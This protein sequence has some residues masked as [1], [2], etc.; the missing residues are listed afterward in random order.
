MRPLLLTLIATVLLV[1]QQPPPTAAQQRP[2]FRGGTQFIR[3]DAYPTSRD[4]RII[5]GLTADD[6]EILEDGKPQKVDSFDFIKFATFTPEVERRDPSSQREGFDM[7]ADPRYRVFVIFVDMFFSNTTAAAPIDTGMPVGANTNPAIS[8]DVH[9]IQRPLVQFLDRIL[10]P[11]DLYGFLTSRNSVKDLVLAQKSTVTEAQIADLFRASFIERDEADQ[12]DM[13]PKLPADLLELKRRFRADASYTALEGLIQQ[14]GSLRQE[15]KNVI[16][17]SNL[18]I[19]DRDDTKLIDHHDP[20]VP[21][22]G[23][24][25]GR[26]GVGD[27][28]QPGGNE[29]YC[30]AE[31]QRLVHIDFND[32]YLRLLREA[33]KENVAFYPVTPSGLQTTQVSR[34]PRATIADVHAIQRAN[35]DLRSLASESDGIAIVDTNDLNAGL[36]RIANDLSAYYLLGYYTTNTSWDGGLRT[37]KVRLKPSGQTVRARRQYRA[38]TQAEI[39][40]LTAGATNQAPGASAPQTAATTAREMAL[41]VLERASRPFA[42]YTAVSGRTLTVVTELSAES[43]QFGRWKNGADVEVEASGPNGAPAGTA[44]GKLE[45]GAYAAAIPLA[46]QS[47]VGLARVAVHL[48]GPNDP[49]ADDWL[50]VRPATGALLGDPLAYRSASRIAPRPV[51]AFEFARNERIKIEWP[52]LAPLDRRQ[53]RLLDRTG[54]PLPVD[55]PLAEDTARSVLIVDMSLSGLPHADYLIEL[56]AGAGGVTDSK[57]L[58]IRIR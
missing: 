2:V 1:A 55:L 3:V 13:C 5:E 22:I 36:R 39:A 57:L 46:L 26:L 54:K 43:I 7:A 12:L 27:P 11:Q 33:R 50:N 16:L 23:I 19:R 58:A 53:V 14:L 29:G 40:A 17:V 35:E 24:A 15:R 49:P 25:G 51:A 28:R 20:V 32:H 52:V 10:G 18:L 9:R 4:G 34:D 8:G 41:G 37:I 42:A 56:T 30:A 47:G 21:R 48:R 6:F 31:A 38:P 45:P 44:R